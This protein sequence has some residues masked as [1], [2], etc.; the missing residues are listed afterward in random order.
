[1]INCPRP[2]R[3]DALRCHGHTD[4]LRSISRRL[5]ALDAWPDDDEALNRMA[6]GEKCAEDCWEGCGS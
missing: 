3:A 1:M 4:T 5:D 6:R 2:V